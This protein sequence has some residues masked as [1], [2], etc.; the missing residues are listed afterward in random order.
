MTVTL[1][2]YLREVK[3][4][5]SKPAIVFVGNS[6]DLIDEAVSTY[7]TCQDDVETVPYTNDAALDDAVARPPFVDE[8][9]TLVVDPA[10]KIKTKKLEALLE[11]VPEHLGIA[12]VFRDGRKELTVG[13]IPI[14]GCNKMSAGTQMLQDYITQ[15]AKA[16]G[17]EV[18]LQAVYYLADVFSEQPSRLK[19]ELL[20]TKV[21]TGRVQLTVDDFVKCLT[22]SP[23]WK[24]EDV[25]NA[26]CERNLQRAM[27]QV[28]ALLDRDE[29]LWLLL[30]ILQQRFRVLQ[31][32]YRA[33]RAGE[34]AKSYFQRKK[35]PIW[36]LKDVIHAT[37]FVKEQHLPKFF[38]VLCTSEFRIRNSEAM[39]R[40]LACTD[41]VYRLCR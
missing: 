6:P 3:T 2:R 23:V 12:L 18:D 41:M 26:I 19:F 17:C 33:K 10:D 37:D 1:V 4:F 29:E 34:D 40:R 32:V 15:H 7:L 13:K 16:I 38:D 9:R 5:A 30:H 20:K 28:Q 24:A 31:G 39:T 36:W 27:T 11:N 8:I 35:I 22:S 21:F 14:I 25:V